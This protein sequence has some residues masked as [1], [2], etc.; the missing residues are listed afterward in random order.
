MYRSV[1]HRGRKASLVH[2]DAQKHRLVFLKNFMELD[3]IEPLQRAIDA[4]GYSQPTPIQAQAI[5]PLLNGR[6]LLGVAP[7]G[8]GKTAAFALPVL[9]KLDEW[10]IEGH[11]NPRALILSPTRELAAQ[12]ADSYETYGQF[13]DLET[14]VIFGGVNEKPQIAA[15]KKGVDIV[16][17]TPGRLLDLMGRGFVDLSEVEHFVLDEADRM[18]DMGFINDIKRVMK[19]LP[20][21]RQNLLFSAT[22]PKEIVELSKKLLHDPVTVREDADE[23]TVERIDQK[24]F[25]VSDGTK[26]KRKVLSAL[27]HGKDVDRAIVF[28]RTK[29]RANRLCKQL[30]SDGHNS[31]PIHGNKSQNARER[32]LNGFRD[33]TYKVLVATDVASRGIDVDEVTHVFNFDLPNVSEDYVHRIGR[34][35][36]AGRDGMAISFCDTDERAYLTDIEKL[37]GE[38][39]E[40]L[41]SADVPAAPRIESS[42]KDDSQ[43]DRSSNGRS[44]K[45]KSNG[46]TSSKS[47][48]QAKP[49]KK[50]RRR[51]NPDVK[52]GAAARRS[53]G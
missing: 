21:K 17:A 11:R 3:L 43:R 8:T 42:A 12:I 7:T 45:K 22:M 4:V 37:I 10:I 20:K 9:Q 14:V 2:Q 47:S 28:T 27:L 52:L 30:I 49:K 29:R 41:K 46:N 19:E 32:A 25:F 44:S 39:V 31:A 38:K 18:L 24:V 6:D 51:R 50:F 23:P 48:E 15:L 53:R 35:G 40:V 1:E 26:Q 33:G 5:P 16:V 36:R 13:L 34:T